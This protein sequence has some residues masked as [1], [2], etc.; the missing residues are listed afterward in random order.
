[1][2]LGIL[3]TDQLE[4]ALQEKY[5]SYSKM[6]Q[7]L[8]FSVD[9][10]LV[11]KTYDVI[12]L[13]YPGNIDNCDAY[14]ITGSKASPYENQNWIKRLAAY[15]LKLHSHQKKL[16]GI[17]FGHQLIAQALGG[18]VEKSKKGWGVGTASR[19]VFQLKSWMGKGKKKF[20]VLAS[21]QDQV[22]Q[23]PPNAELIAG[24]E[25]C[26]NASFQIGNHILTF[27]GHPEFQAAY[28]RQ[29]IVGRRE[30]IGSLLADQALES[31]GEET[32]HRQI[33]R[34]MMSFLKS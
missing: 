29:L 6:F 28:L 25:F 7:K 30:R 33:A 32:D 2:K 22:T 1:V 9:R 17:C 24:S 12:Q 19:D 14:L 27:Q 31:L 16:I 10:Q 3:E 13:E 18:L 20:K 8:F 26:P 34:W 5:G 11:F 4:L 21:H 23:L 15:V